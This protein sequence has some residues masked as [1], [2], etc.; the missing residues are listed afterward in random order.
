M[1]FR[2]SPSQAHQPETRKP[3]DIFCRRPQPFP[4]GAVIL[5]QDS[6]FLPACLPFAPLS[7]YTAFL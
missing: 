4:A 1:T 6:G 3:I 7:N 5:V 2:G